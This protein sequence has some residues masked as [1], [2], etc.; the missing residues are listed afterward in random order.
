MSAGLVNLGVALR[1]L[2]GDLRHP[3]TVQG[4]PWTGLGAFP[5]TICK[6]LVTASMH[7]AHVA[8]LLRQLVALYQA[9]AYDVFGAAHKS[10]LWLVQVMSPHLLRILLL[11]CLWPG[12]DI[13]AA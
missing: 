3:L 12:S 4:V 8:L 6:Q 7:I 1:A 5:K 11:L 9:C 13:T 2:A 10:L